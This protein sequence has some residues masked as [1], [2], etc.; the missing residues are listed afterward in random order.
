MYA[1]LNYVKLV[2]DDS[3]YWIPPQGYTKRQQN[4]TLET[5]EIAIVPSAEDGYVRLGMY[6][7]ASYYAEFN[8]APIPR[9]VS[10]GVNSRAAWTA[11]I[12]NAKNLRPTNNFTV[13]LSSDM[14]RLTGQIYIGTPESNQSVNYEMINQ[15][16]II[17]NTYNLSNSN[18]SLVS[19]NKTADFV[20]LLQS[21]V[22]TDIPF[23]FVMGQNGS[24]GIGG[25]QWNNDSDH[26]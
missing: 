18:T 21:D 19:G 10:L 16:T 7:L 5:C 22:E 20:A 15:Q 3:V 24:L 11:G 4:A 25:P 17:G 1:K 13:G 12:G 23:T 26:S 8:Y 2:I 6:F 14:N 9:Q